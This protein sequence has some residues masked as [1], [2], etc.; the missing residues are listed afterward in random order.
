MTD[1]TTTARPGYRGVVLAMLLIVYTFNFVDRQILGIL[2]PSIKAD[3]ALSD[4]QLGALGGLAFALLYSTLA[5]PLAWLADR[6]SRSWVITVSLAVWSGFTALCGYAGSFWQLFWCR[7]GVGVGEAGGVAPSYALI[8]DYFPAGQRARALSVYSLGIPLGSAAGV[9]LGGWIAATIDWRT[10]FVAVGIAGVVVAPL[11]RLIVREPARPA[12][13]AGAE[14]IAGV[15][16]ILARKRS[17]WLLAFGAASSSMLGYGLAFWLPSLLKRSFG[18]ELAGIGRFYGGLLL[19]GGVA[20]VLLGGFVGDRLGARDRGMYARLPAVSF[21]IAVPFFAAGILSSSS[22]AAFL[23]WLVPQ[24]LVYV[25]LAPVIAA[26]QHLVP[27]HM[28]ATASAT[29]LLINNLIGLGA[30]TLVM[31]A[32][33]DA[34]TAR[35]GT[36]A[37]R[38][39]MLS[40]L[41]LYLLAGVLMWLAAAPLRRDWVD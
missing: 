33:S 1:R 5:I 12:T 23:L 28:R 36:E 3:L 17:F 20:G 22:T 18:M 16:G 6:T 15:F 30:G 8:A 19:I 2:A 4:T 21:W 32:L 24:A 11:F 27:A 34:M 14:P 7:L 13:P 10:A 29:F 26:V 35:F 9:M 31:G 39:A 38:Y 40:G 41:G 25:W 37:L